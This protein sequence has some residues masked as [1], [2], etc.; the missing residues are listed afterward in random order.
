VHCSIVDVLDAVRQ[1]RE[2]QPAIVDPIAAALVRNARS[3]ID[4]DYAGSP[5][6]VDHGANEARSTGPRPGQRY[7]DWTRFGG[8]SHHALVF[9]NVDDAAALERLGPRWSGLVRIS[10]NPDVDPARA[11]VPSGGMILL[12]PDGHIGFRLPATHTEAIATLD[13]HLSSYLIPREERPAAVDR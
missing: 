6:V 2:V 5:L 3:M 10:H 9:G 11:G 7:P 4:V 8:T 1:G 13:R 12:R